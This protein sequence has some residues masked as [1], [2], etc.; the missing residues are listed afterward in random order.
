[1]II[2]VPKL[3]SFMRTEWTNIVKIL[4]RVPR[5]SKKHVLLFFGTFLMISNLI[6]LWSENVGC[7][8]LITLFKDI[9]YSEKF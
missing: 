1:M 5:I 9:V 7:I 6:S 8:R 4:R 3:Y 2:A